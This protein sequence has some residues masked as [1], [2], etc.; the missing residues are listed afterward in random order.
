MLLLALA[1]PLFGTLLANSTIVYLALG[2]ALVVSG[3]RCIVLAEHRCREHAGKR[4]FGGAF[5]AGI[6]S[7]AMLSPCCTP[8]VL[9]ILNTEAQNGRA[10]VAAISLALFA[11]GHSIPAVVTSVAVSVPLRRFCAWAQSDGAA[12][13]TGALQI[14]V[15]AF[16]VVLA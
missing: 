13:I 1:L 10:Q 15:G 11:L 5:C 12:T 14:G 2:G 4:S 6:T 16:Y 9:A 8:L 7:S 3:V